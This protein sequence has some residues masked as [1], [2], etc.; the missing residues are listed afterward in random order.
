MIILYIN[1][2][3]ARILDIIYNNYIV[4][5]VNINIGKIFLLAFANF[6]YV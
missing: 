3:T 6:F 4:H 5:V 2:W 1:I